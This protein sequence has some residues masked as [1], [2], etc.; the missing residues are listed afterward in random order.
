MAT[1]SFDTSYD[2]SSS[3]NSSSSDTNARFDTALDYIVDVLL[4]LSMFGCVATVITFILFRPMRTQPIKL[5]VYLCICMFF[6]Q[7]F[8]YLTFYLE[9]T[10]MC[11]PC[12]M[13]FHYFFLADFIWTFSIASNFYQM[14]VRRNRDA[15]SL[16]IIYHGAAWSI[17]L[18]IVVAMAATKNYNNQG[19]Y[20]YMD[21]GVPIFLAFFVPG[22]FIVTSNC[23]IFIFTVKEIHDTLKSA[24]NSDKKEKS[25]EIKVYFSIFASIGL[26]WL[27]GFIMVFIQD[28][29]VQEIFLVLF[30]ILTPTQGL[31]IFISYCCNERVVNRWGE[32]FGIKMLIDHS[33]ATSTTA[34]GRL[35]STHSSHTHSG[36]S[37]HSAHSSSRNAAAPSRALLSSSSSAQSASASASASASS[38]S[39]AI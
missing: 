8:F 17:P 12:A 5:V 31:L 24:P 25:K 28:T 36:H 11:I 29:V 6:A 21:S 32:V 33:G 7:F 9:N 19:G 2:L 39:A 13:I 26:S 18:I 23:I 4:A 15:E 35:S 30:S 38:S 14:I 3:Y 16:E 27:F 22:L 34:S 20:C 1:S 10:I 37:Q